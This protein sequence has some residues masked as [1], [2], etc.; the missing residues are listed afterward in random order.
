MSQSPDPIDPLSTEPVPDEDDEWANPAEGDVQ[1]D[2]DGEI[3]PVEEQ[4]G[5]MGKVLV[6]PMTYGTV[7]QFFGDGRRSN[8]D[9]GDLAVLFGEHVI[10]PDLDEHYN[11][12]TADDVKSMK[13]LAP[14]DYITAIMLAS[15]IDPEDVQ[16]NDDGSADV[17]VSGN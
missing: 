4:A 7:Q 17:T 16:M 11:G 2:G 6:K 1:R 15:G 5:E 14:R 9:A 10:K 8:L 3:I 12:I 13:P